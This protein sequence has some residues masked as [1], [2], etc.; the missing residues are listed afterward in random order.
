MSAIGVAKNLDFVQ[1]SNREEGFVSNKELLKFDLGIA[2]YGKFGYLQINGEIP[3]QRT[4]IAPD[5][6]NCHA[7]E[8]FFQHKLIELDI[9]WRQD[10]FSRATGATGWIR[11]AMSAVAHCVPSLDISTARMKA[12]VCFNLGKTARMLVCI[13]LN[14]FETIK[15][16]LHFISS[17]IFSRW[18]VF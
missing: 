10:E 2:E 14:D 13:C 15:I 6:S 9:P 1:H 8:M 5:L 16:K 3:F 4:C 11:T 12:F 7:V 17:T 18:V